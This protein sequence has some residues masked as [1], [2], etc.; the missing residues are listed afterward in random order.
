MEQE[1]KET[2]QKILDATF[3]GFKYISFRLSSSLQRLAAMHSNDMLNPKARFETLYN[4][5]LN[6]TVLYQGLEYKLKNLIR[7]VEVKDMK[8]FLA[9]EQGSG[10]KSKNTYVVINPKIRNRARQQLV[11][12]YPAVVF[13]SNIDNETSVDVEKFKTKKKYNDDI[14]EFLALILNNQQAIKIKKYRKK[15]K[16]YAQALGLGLELNETNIPGNRN[17]ENSKR[18][19]NKK[20]SEK[21]AEVSKNKEIEKLNRIIVRQKIK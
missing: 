9:I 17:N 19:E 14:K 1:A 5:N 4:T 15:V 12:D 10:K 2:D 20:K 6:D 7:I 18:N 3:D 11:E 8:L 21:K 13:Q 16:L